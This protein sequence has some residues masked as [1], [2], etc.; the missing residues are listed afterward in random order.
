MCCVLSVNLILKQKYICE[1]KKVEYDCV[2]NC[3]NKKDTTDRIKDALNE[4]LAPY[5]FDGIKIRCYA[6]DLLGILLED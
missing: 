1:V 2:I 6:S 4:I 5:S 3:K